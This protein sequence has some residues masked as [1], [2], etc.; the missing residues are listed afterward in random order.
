M[1]RDASRAKDQAVATVRELLNN[2]PMAA[3]SEA[4]RVLE[5]TPDHL[6]LLFLK[7][8]AHHRMAEY[9]QAVIAFQQVLKSN[10]AITEVHF[11]LALSQAS[12]QLVGA[13]IAS[14]RRVISLEPLH[15]SAWRVLSEMLFKE[16]DFDAASEA[17]LRHIEASANNPKLREAGAAMIRNDIPRA[18]RL[19]KS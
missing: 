15:R 3:L 19:L 18:E 10:D 16:G 8:V 11:Q 5:E 17:Q 13:A 6:E 7:G 1:S 12:L 2:D 14:L 9:Q 4:G